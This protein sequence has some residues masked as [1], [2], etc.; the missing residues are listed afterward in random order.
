MTHNTAPYLGVGVVCVGGCGGVVGGLLGGVV[1]YVPGAKTSLLWLLPFALKI[2]VSTLL[3]SISRRIAS[4]SSAFRNPC[5]LASGS[6]AN[7]FGA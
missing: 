2:S 5:C 3:A 4:S 7:T 1:V 6:S